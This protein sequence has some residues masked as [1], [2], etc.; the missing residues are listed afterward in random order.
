M[1]EVGSSV[2][3]WRSIPGHEQY[4]VSCWG[5]VRNINGRDKKTS[6]SANGYMIVGLYKNGRRSNVLV[7]R[8]V[9]SAF[10]GSPPDGHEVN[11]IDGKKTNNL[12]GNLEYVTKSENQI[13]AIALGLSSPP[14][15]RARGDNHWTRKYPELLAYGDR[16]GAKKHPDKILKGQDCPSSRLTEKDVLKI[17][18]LACDGTS[19]KELSFLFGV[20]RRNISMIVNR[21][22]WR[23]I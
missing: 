14:K 6:L 8:A 20:T 19:K 10:F 9:I 11:H 3:E 17:R 15:N 1:V 13:H 23:H 22:S 21:K 2:E 7:H 5:N 16:N 18:E 12:L 4:E